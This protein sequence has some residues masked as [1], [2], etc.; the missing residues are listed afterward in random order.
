MNIEPG[1][2]SLEALEGPNGPATATR[3]VSGHDYGRS[4]QIVGEDVDVH[5]LS[6]KVA[7]ISLLRS[8]KAALT[9][10]FEKAT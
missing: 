10:P 8:A 7:S 6:L 4:S 5:T 9:S 3:N 1:D 2:M